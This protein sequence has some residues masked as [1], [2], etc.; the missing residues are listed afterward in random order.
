MRWVRELA[1]TVFDNYV[2]WLRITS[3]ITLTSCPAISIPC[4]FTKD[5]R[6][7]GLQLVGRPRG[8]ADLLA[9][10]AAFEETVDIARLVPIDPRIGQTPGSA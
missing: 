3:A 2:E 9:A 7:V 5:G 6:P 4:G 8:E 1:G 10:A